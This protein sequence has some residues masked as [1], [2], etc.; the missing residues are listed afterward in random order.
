MFCKQSYGFG[1]LVSLSVVQPASLAR[2]YA[3]GRSIRLSQ[4]GSTK[5]NAVDEVLASV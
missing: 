2:R 5:R 3:N 4:V 1:I